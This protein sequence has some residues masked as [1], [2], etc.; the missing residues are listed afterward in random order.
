MVT[1]SWSRMQQL[2]HVIT[3]ERQ[4]IGDFSLLDVAFSDLM[5][6]LSAECISQF[7]LAGRW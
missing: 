5:I 7:S 1:E 3:R 6:N 2:D 4:F